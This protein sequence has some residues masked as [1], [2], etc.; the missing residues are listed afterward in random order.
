MQSGDWFDLLVSFPIS[1]LFLDPLLFPTLSNPPLQLPKTL[2]WV[3]YRWHV[4]VGGGGRE[5]IRDAQS[6]CLTC[7]TVHLTFPFD[8]P[9]LYDQPSTVLF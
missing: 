3:V 8:L 1:S 2:W 6:W 4:V 9:K 7:L 5:K